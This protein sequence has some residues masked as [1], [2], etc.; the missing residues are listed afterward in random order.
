MLFKEIIEL[1]EA[2]WATWWKPCSPFAPLV[3]GERQVLEETES[4]ISS[5]QT[6]KQTNIH[7]EASQA[8]EHNHIISNKTLNYY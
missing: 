4:I 7:T 8:E 1:F 5:F 3:V 2:T 6:I